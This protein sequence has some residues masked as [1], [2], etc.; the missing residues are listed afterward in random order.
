MCASFHATLLRGAVGSD[1]WYSLV[2]GRLV[3]RSGIPHEDTLT[4]ISHGQAWVDQEWLGHLLLYGLWV[5][6]RWPAVLV[7]VVV[8]YVAAFSVAA[9]AARSGGASE[10]STAILAV[11]AFLTALGNTVPRA[12][13]PAYV[14]FAL[15][16][17]LLLA[18]D[19]RP[20]PRVYLVF[21]LL[22]VWANIHGSVVLGAALV[23]LRGLVLVVAGI[24]SMAAKRTWMPRAASLLVLPWLCTLASPYGIALPGYYRRVL[25]NRELTHAVTE[26]GPSTLRAQPLFF[27]LLIVSL[28][29]LA[30]SRRAVTP[31]AGIALVGTGLLGLL[32]IRNVVWFALTAAMVV[33]LALDALRPPVPSRRRVRL[34]F[35]VAS[36]GVGLAL[37][38][39]GT[40]VAHGSAWF[41]D[42]YPQGAAKAVAAAA[43][44]D[45]SARIFSDEIYSDWLLFED[46][47]LAGRVA[48]DIRYE[49]LTQAELGRIVTFR[50]EQGIGWQDIAL[51]Y[52]IL[53][54]DPRSD[55]TAIKLIEHRPGARVLY[56]GKQAVVLLAGGGA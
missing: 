37:L 8:L 2:S 4:S 7:A 28:L 39:G 11:A 26:W 21:V 52:K 16:L 53:V 23:S 49:L 40:R 10:R 44:A 56:D 9:G 32:A 41:E 13:V 35:G 51:G 48:F 25:D 54:L 38:V 45:P 3:A 34:N 36:V 31:F 15:V 6:G 55:G 14:L 42:G 46:P 43:K 18:D 22:A 30:R 17:A 29:L 20:S 50:L 27:A 5:A 33:P 12:Q 47:A 19:R 24:R 1:T